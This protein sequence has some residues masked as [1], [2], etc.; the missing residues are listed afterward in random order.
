MLL[1]TTNCSNLGR[2]VLCLNER[3][4]AVLGRRCCKVKPNHFAIRAKMLQ[5]TLLSSKA[6]LR[7]RVGKAAFKGGND[8]SA[9]N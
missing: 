1:P 9:L 7:N 2:I 5:I 3:K 6:S 4:E 8:A